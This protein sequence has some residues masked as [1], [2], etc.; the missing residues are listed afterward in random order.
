MNER[1]GGTPSR[2]ARD[3]RRA[4]P[5]ANDRP[6]ADRAR[7]RRPRTR[8]TNHRRFLTF[9]LSPC[10]TDHIIAR[11][12]YLGITRAG[13]GWVGEGLARP[14]ERVTLGLLAPTLRTWGHGLS[15]RAEADTGPTFAGR[16][17]VCCPL[18]DPDQPA[19]APGRPGGGRRL[20]PLC[21]QP[22]LLS[23]VTSGLP[24]RFRSG[25]DRRPVGDD[26][27]DPRR[28]AMGATRSE[29]TR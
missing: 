20:C 15:A 6:V 19:G 5:G 13:P 12:G 17:E 25:I 21:V 28:F 4:G 27:A 18:S 2:Q 16:R 3:Y 29:L 9:G 14:G 24:I 23:S 11:F 22:L 7:R 8:K 10:D 26:R 1:C